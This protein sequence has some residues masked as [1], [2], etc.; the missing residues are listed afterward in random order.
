MKLVVKSKA[1]DTYSFLQFNLNTINIDR[2][3]LESSLCEKYVA[4]VLEAFIT[5][6]D[7]GSQEIAFL[8]LQQ[9]F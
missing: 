9:L 5:I 1:K 8:F 7:F 6:P 3:R 4:S 2:W